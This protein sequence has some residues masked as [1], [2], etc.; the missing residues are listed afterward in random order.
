MDKFDIV[1]NQSKVYKKKPSKLVEMIF[2]DGVS[3]R[4]FPSSSGAYELNGIF[5]GKGRFGKY[6]FY[7]FVQ[8]LVKKNVDVLSDGAIVRA[9]FILHSYKKSW[10]RDIS[11]WKKNTYNTDRQIKSIARHLFCKYPIP[12][13]LEE[14]WLSGGKAYEWEFDLYIFMGMGGS[15]RKFDKLPVPISKRESHYFQNAPDNYS[16]V[17]ALLYG[18]VKALGGN[19]HMVRAIMESRIY[20]AF[21]GMGTSDNWPF[22]ETILRFFCEQ[23]M[24]DVRQ[25]PPICDYISHVKFDRRQVPQP[26]GGWRTL[27][28]ENPN[29]KINGRTVAAL[30][31]GM[32]AWHKETHGKRNN[33]PK[34]WEGFNIPDYKVSF[35]K[36]EKRRTYTFT[37]LITAASLRSEG[38]AHGH[39]VAG[40]VNSCNSGRTSIWS[41]CV[42]DAFN[43]NKNLLTIEVSRDKKIVQCRGKANRLANRQEWLIVE[44]F[45][46]ERDLDIARY[47]SYE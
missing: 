14:V 44:R 35:G 26:G 38:R 22:W 7:K 31:R 47:V 36:E 6:E 39:C 23:Q 27:P 43:F 37:Q 30:V 11:T 13:F 9:L 10:I 1:L 17:E 33:A 32:E 40:Y 24:M 28:P 21:N 34:N 16:T 12:K 4:D 42:E 25:I 46:R 3:V 15:P 5:R 19:E 2:N 29:F 20:R 8:S 41:M 45:A 18:K